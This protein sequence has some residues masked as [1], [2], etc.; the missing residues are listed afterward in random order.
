MEAEYDYIQPEILNTFSPSGFPLHKL[1]LKIGA[2]LMLLH[3]QDP[4]NGVCNGTHLRLLRST[5]CILKYRVLGGD[6]ANNVVFIPYMALDSGLQDSPIPFRHLQFLKKNE[7]V[8][9]HV[10]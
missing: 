5:H 7:L 9:V 4:M 8:R 10:S 2:P 3:N 1:E 6:N